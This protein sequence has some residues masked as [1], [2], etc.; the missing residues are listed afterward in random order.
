MLAI[1]IM[2][3]DLNFKHRNGYSCWL[4]WARC[5]RSI[6]YQATATT[7]IRCLL[8]QSKPSP[9]CCREAQQMNAIDLTQVAINGLWKKTFCDILSWFC[10][11]FSTKDK[12]KN[13]QW[14]IF[15]MY[16]NHLDDGI[17]AA[18]V[19]SR[20]CFRNGIKF[21]PPVP[22]ANN[23]FC[24]RSVCTSAGIPAFPTSFRLLACDTM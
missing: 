5:C 15:N 18:T 20:L 2:A 6:P 3:N 4:W 22:R 10:L 13:K 23:P 19:S 21:V 14:F 16:C 8:F 7:P 24:N 11:L 17:T 1:R 9:Y 12:Q